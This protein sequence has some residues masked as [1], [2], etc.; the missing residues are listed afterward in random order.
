MIETD[1]DLLDAFTDIAQNNIPA[2]ITLEEQQSDDED[3]YTV[4]VSSLRDMLH[5]AFMLGFDH[6]NQGG[7]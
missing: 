1:K 6:R 3:F 4:H 5:A 7:C 2:L